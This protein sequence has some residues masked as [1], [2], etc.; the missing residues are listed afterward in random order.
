MNEE[1][2]KEGKKDGRKE[3]RKEG[4]VGG[5]DGETIFLVSLILELECALSALQ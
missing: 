1:G 3:G 2:R 4:S 5:C